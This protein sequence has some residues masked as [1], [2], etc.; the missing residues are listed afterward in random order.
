MNYEE[1]TQSSVWNKDYTNSCSSTHWYSEKQIQG[2][3]SA[4]IGSD[5]TDIQ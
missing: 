3:I 5:P 4:Y 1:I 2:R